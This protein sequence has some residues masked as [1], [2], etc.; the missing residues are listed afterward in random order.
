MIRDRASAV[1]ASRRF[2]LFFLPPTVRRSS[3]PHVQAGEE[4]R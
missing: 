1:G 3:A 2:E 4:V